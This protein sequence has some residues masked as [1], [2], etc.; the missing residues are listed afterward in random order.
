MINI[1]N[2]KLLSA[3]PI[4]AKNVPIFINPNAAATSKPAAAVSGYDR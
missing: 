4:K 1:K 2:N 3:S